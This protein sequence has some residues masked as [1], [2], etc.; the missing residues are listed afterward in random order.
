MVAA[1]VSAA[2]PAGPVL[3]GHSL[4]GTW[5]GV[6]RTQ[7]FRRLCSSQYG[8]VGTFIVIDCPNTDGR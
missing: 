5:F 4:C 7:L 1:G 8:A 6:A 3:A 2:E